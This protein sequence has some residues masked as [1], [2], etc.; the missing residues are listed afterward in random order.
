VAR[1]SFIQKISDKTSRS[2]L[3][4]LTS[5][6][7]V[8]FYCHQTTLKLASSNNFGQ[9]VPASAA[10]SFNTPG[11]SIQNHG[12]TPDTQAQQAL[13]QP[14]RAI[15]L[16]V[17]SVAERAVVFNLIL[18]IV[19]GI[20]MD[21]YK[22][23]LDVIL[24]ALNGLDKYGIPAPD[25]RSE[26]WPLMAEQ[27]KGHPN[28][29]RAFSIAASHNMDTTCVQISPFTLSTSLRTLSEE[30][31]TLMGPLY[32]RRLMRFHMQRQS[33]LKSVIEAPPEGHPPTADCSDANQMDVK[34]KWELVCTDL[35]VLPTPQALSALELK[36]MFEEAEKN[37]T[38][39]LL[40][41]GLRFLI[42]TIIPHMILPVVAEYGAIHL[43][44]ARLT[45]V[46]SRFLLSLL[47][48]A[49]LYL[50]WTATSL[51]HE[52]NERRAAAKLDASPVPVIRG[53]WRFP[54][55][56][57]MI[58]RMMKDIE[59]DYN[60]QWLAELVIE[61]GDIF[62]MRLLGTDAIFTTNPVYI[63]QMIS[64]D[65]SIW[66]KGKER[67]TDLMRDFLGDGVFNSDG[68]M[69]KFHRSMTRPFFAKEKIV[70]FET[71]AKHA[72]EAMAKIKE[73]GGEPVDFQIYDGLSATSFLFGKCVDCMAAPLRPPY[74]HS[75]S[76]SEMDQS[77]TSK[78]Y[79]PEAFQT[80]LK[81]CAFRLTIGRANWP[82]FEFRGDEVKR[83]IGPI[84]AYV[85]PIVQRALDQN[86]AKGTV[87]GKDPEEG[88]E[89][90]ETLLDHL[91]SVT[92]DRKII[93]DE[94]LNILLAARDTT[95]HLITAV[96]YFL[97]T[98]D[99]EI[100]DRLR[101][102][103]TD[104]VGPKDVPSYDH[105]KHMKYLR[106]V[107][108]DLWGPDANEFDPDRWLD[109]RNKK[110]FL[111]NPFI[112]VP[113]HGG[114]RMCLGQQT[115]VDVAFAPEAYA[116]GMLPPLEWKNSGIGRKAVEKVWPM[117]HL[118][119]YL[120]ASPC[121]LD[122]ISEIILPITVVYATAHR[123]MSYLTSIENGLI[124]SSLSIF[125]PFLMTNLFGILQALNERRL[126][127]QF[128][129]ARIPAIRGRCS[130]M[131]TSWQ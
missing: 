27:A 120:K 80:V 7:V 73:R 104:F 118:T 38:Y 65:F 94:L 86:A 21:D 100:C 34:Q 99:P 25:E 85:E 17:F 96:I 33:A 130:E 119:M 75:G 106:A 48:L 126:V 103:I 113:F 92:K 131:W 127:R 95:A 56:V 107:L 116:P 77:S 28:A 62:N 16:L 105:I 110:Y 11:S 128:N 31:A 58:Q 2:D 114:P 32:L 52:Y 45:L 88:P 5:S 122:K 19:Y 4:D 36:E 78:G 108:N 53:P 41:P 47:S 70:H 23:N 51:L 115:F 87:E 81:A 93:R 22:P 98:E 55:N 60:S 49:T 29:T 3:M 84:H 101:K 117:A 64:T 18:R 91:V 13:N 124:L 59:G 123:Y 82:L 76:N 8:F 35:M 57:D 54:G 90:H 40:S 69:W 129:A 43:A 125:A 15:S 14:S 37:H 50:L 6:D 24:N 61:H 9:T 68:A 26:I 74:G 44:I 121:I 12:N 111:A 67:F 83:H 97:S 30:D 102:E 46:E 66:V 10:P 109:E 79:F 63:K 71:F 42:T 1:F 39:I 112:F 89:E 72:D 20:P